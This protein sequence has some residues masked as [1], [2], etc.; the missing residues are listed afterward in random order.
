MDGS[1]ALSFIRKADYYSPKSVYD[2]LYLDFSKRAHESKITQSSSMSFLSK[3]QQIQKSEQKIEDSLINKQKALKS[4]LKLLKAKYNAEEIKELQPAPSINK[5]SKIL[6]TQNLE[7]SKDMR[8]K[9]ILS[10]L[11]TS[12]FAKMARNAPNRHIKSAEINLEELARNGPIIKQDIKQEIIDKNIYLQQLRNKVNARPKILEPEE[13]PT[14]LDMSVIDRN[15][16]WLKVKAHNLEKIK[17]SMIDKDLEG[18]TFSPV[19]T[20]RMRYKNPPSYLQRESARSRSLNTSYY[21]LYLLK[22]QS[23]SYS[24]DHQEK[25]YRQNS[26]R[27][28]KENHNKGP[29]SALLYSPLA[30][31]SQKFSFNAGLDIKKFINAAKPTGK[32]EHSKNFK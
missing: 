25:N 13:P 28:I 4:K 30:P 20:P 31:T 32:Y 23:V 19:L 21:Q 12:R 16:H 8:H 11:S 22:K 17:K 7:K 27:K 1:D 9:Y 5:I 26:E 10:I 6:A 29:K 3:P 15:N 14:M 18:C 2:R 24:N